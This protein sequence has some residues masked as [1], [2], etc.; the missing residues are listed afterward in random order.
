LKVG[1]S[2]L[3]KA[4][5]GKDSRQPEK[6]D[7]SKQSHTGDEV[8]VE[9]S[10]TIAISPFEQCKNPSEENPEGRQ[11]T[12]HPSKCVDIQNCDAQDKISD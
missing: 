8:K 3:L 12:E 7:E 9:P 2:K 1:K 11:G 10:K 6:Q 4:Q 5:E